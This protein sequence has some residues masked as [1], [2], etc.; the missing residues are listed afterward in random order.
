MSNSIKNNVE[1]SSTNQELLRDAIYKYIK[2]PKEVVRNYELIV[3]D[4][5]RD[6]VINEDLHK[7]KILADEI[8]SID[9]L[10]SIEILNN[11]DPSDV[12]YLCIDENFNNKSFHGKCITIFPI[13]CGIDKF[14]NKFSTPNML[15][16]DINKKFLFYGILKQYTYI[17]E[18]LNSIH[19]YI[20]SDDQKINVDNILNKLNHN[21]TSK[22]DKIREKLEFYKNNNINYSIGSRGGMS[23]DIKDKE[24]FNLIYSI[25]IEFTEIKL[26]FEPYNVSIIDKS[27]N[28][29]F[30][31]VNGIKNLGS[32]TINTIKNLGN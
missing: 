24:L 22:L 6:N 12:G 8:G 15:N 14:H 20:N 23:C 17:V 21:L 5:E 32:K 7:L 18:S 2:N 13:P 30:K 19:D 3:N 26:D 28:L 11:K 25:M 31:A 1:P 10:N 29:G 4:Q 16:K 9:I 27:K